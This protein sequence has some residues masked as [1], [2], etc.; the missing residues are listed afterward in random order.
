MHLDVMRPFMLLAALEAIER[1]QNRQTND[2]KYFEFGKTYHKTETKYK[3]HKHLTIT[4]TGKSTMQNWHADQ[5]DTNIFIL[6][7]YVDNVLRKLGI[8]SYRTNQPN[9]DYF[10]YGTRYEKGPMKLV[11]YGR[12]S[13][14]LTKAFSVKGEVYYADFDWDVILKLAANRVKYSELNKYPTVRRDLAL[15]ID[16]KVKFGDIAFLANKTLKG[17]ITAINL[18][19]VYENDE[20]LGK[21]KKSYAISLTFEDKSKTLKDK[22]V[23]A[24]MAKLIKTLENK[25]GAVLR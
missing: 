12:L 20:Q 4:L 17:K 18:F 8:D 9:A 14:K 22:E 3:E 25:V 6:K 24:M 7:A 19:D 1:S 23:E 21:N 15:V 10:A 13:N 2:L 5:K 16:K 11:E